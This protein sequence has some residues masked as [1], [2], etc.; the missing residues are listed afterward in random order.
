MKILKSILLTYSGVS[1]EKLNVVKRVGNIYQCGKILNHWQHGVWGR[2]MDLALSLWRPLASREINIWDSHTAGS[3]LKIWETIAFSLWSQNHLHFNVMVGLA[4][5]TY[6][7]H[8]DCVKQLTLT[9]SYLLPSE[10]NRPARAAD[11]AGPTANAT[12]L[13]SAN[14]RFLLKPKNAILIMVSLG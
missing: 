11:N 10:T 3:C 14:T 13:H 6:P 4:T 7:L 12:H 5:T 1:V 2:N 8:A 9:S